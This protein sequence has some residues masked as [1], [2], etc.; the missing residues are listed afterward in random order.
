MSGTADAMT[1]MAERLGAI[2]EELDDMALDALRRA[3]SGDVDSAETGY[4]L[5]MERRI[6]TARRALARAIVA[7]GEGPS[8]SVVDDGA[9]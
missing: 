4:A 3:S 1:A 8:A 7:L 9:S 2:V 6:L 5:G